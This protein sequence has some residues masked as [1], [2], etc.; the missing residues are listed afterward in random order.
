MV[1][2]VDQMRISI[3]DGCFADFRDDYLPRYLSNRPWP[4]LLWPAQGGSRPSPP[5]SGHRCPAK[6]GRCRIIV[7]L[8][9]LLRFCC[10]TWHNRPGKSPGG[11]E[12]VSAKCNNR[13]AALCQVQPSTGSVLQSATIVLDQPAKGASDQGIANRQMPWQGRRSGF[14]RTCK[15]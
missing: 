12:V 5:S 9:M 13:S 15:T 10:C 4:S 1:R 3:E 11:A 7:T 6:L 14:A 8:C 2:L